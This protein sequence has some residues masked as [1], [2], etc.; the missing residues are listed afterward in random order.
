MAMQSAARRRLVLTATFACFSAAVFPSAS[1]EDTGATVTSVA[2]TRERLYAELA[3]DVEELEQRGSILK[4]VVR[5]ATP[6]VVHIEARRD[7]EAA[8]PARGESEE[9]GSGV[10]IERRGKFYVLTNR[11]VIKYSTVAGINIKLADGRIV[12][13]KQTW[14]DPATDVAIMS[15]VTDG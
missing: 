9:A 14:S 2:S 4:R 6:A 1:A 3:A 12:H 7:T 8:R 10:I 5:L 15:I 11:H 13:P